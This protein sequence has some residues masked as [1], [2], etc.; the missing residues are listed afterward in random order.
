M[1]DRSWIILVPNAHH[2]Y[3][4]DSRYHWITHLE[5]QVVPCMILHD[6]SWCGDRLKGLHRHNTY[7]RDFTVLQVDNFNPFI[8]FCSGSSIRKG[9]LRD[10]EELQ[11]LLL[12]VFGRSART[13]KVWSTLPF[14]AVSHPT[15]PNY[16]TWLTS[17]ISTMADT[18]NQRAEQIP[19]RA[20]ALQTVSN[21]RFVLFIGA[22]EHSRKYPESSSVRTLQYQLIL[23][24]TGLMI[25]RSPR[26]WGPGRVSARRKHSTWSIKE[27]PTERW[28][29]IRIDM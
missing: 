28:Y 22:D 5:S 19:V 11:D 13:Y 26:I 4:H 9:P 14:S 8:P 7:H 23:S 15:S 6:T 17:E 24:S 12:A 25:R 18:V 29:V 1:A 16:N 20:P 27:F 10:A 21:D 2:E 3:S